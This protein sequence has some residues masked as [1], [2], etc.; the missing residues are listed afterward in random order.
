[1][2]ELTVVGPGGVLRPDILTEAEAQALLD[3]YG[4][5]GKAITIPGGTNLQKYLGRVDGGFYYDDATTSGSTGG[6]IADKVH[7]SVLSTDIP[8]N[9]TIIAVTH[10]NH[11]FTGEVYGDVFQGWSKYGSVEETQDL[12]ADAI[13]EHAESRDHPY[14]TETDK[15]FVEL[16]DGTEAIT[17]TEATRAMTSLRTQNLLDTFGVGARSIVVA[18]NTDLAAFFKDKKF[19]VYHL[20]GTS[21]YTNAPEAGAWFEIV[22][23]SHEVLNYKSLVAISSDAR[24]YTAVIN[25]GSFSGWKKK[26]ELAD[27][28]HASGTVDGLTKVLDSISSTDK[29]N[30]G[31]A[32]AVKVAYDTAINANNNANNRVPLTRRIN[33]LALTGDINITP[34]LIGTYT[35]AEINNLVNNAATDLRLGTPQTFKERR[36]TERMSGGVMTSWADYG[37]SNYWLLLRPLQIY[38]NGTWALV[39]YTNT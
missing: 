35:S 4:V 38:R 3:R 17:G 2:N 36:C 6:P 5:G 30:A 10:G 1:M 23:M 37:S 19:G 29:V 11:L 32:N 28:P 33:G 15:G 14:A 20:D 22:C 26:I 9:R 39:P 25:A 12:I 34:G 24:L 7:Y 21:T 18:T 8:G 31:S 13:E 16:A 27:I